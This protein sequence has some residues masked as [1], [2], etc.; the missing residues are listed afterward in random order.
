MSVGA[1]VAVIQMLRFRY[2]RSA[3]ERVRFIERGSCRDVATEVYQSLLD[4]IQSGSAGRLP[5][6]S[7]SSCEAVN[8]DSSSSRD[9]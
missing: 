8:G 9:S 2:D 3:G 7:S 5:A 4:E 6:S 1:M